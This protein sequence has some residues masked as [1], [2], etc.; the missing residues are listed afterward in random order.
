MSPGDL[1]VITSRYTYIEAEMN[2][3][4]SERCR[5]SERAWTLDSRLFLEGI[6]LV[7]MQVRHRLG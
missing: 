3:I 1:V 7:Y 6:A 5:L 4:F 2:D